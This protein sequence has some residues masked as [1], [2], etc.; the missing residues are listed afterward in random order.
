M[1]VHEHT[2]GHGLRGISMNY[3]SHVFFAQKYPNI[4]INKT[5]KEAPNKTKKTDDDAK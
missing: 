1:K 2:R 4:K 3:I 5:K